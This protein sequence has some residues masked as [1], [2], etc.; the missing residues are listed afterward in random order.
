M[1]TFIYR[2][3]ERAGADGARRGE[4]D[5]PVLEIRGDAYSLWSVAKRL[6]LP[7]RPFWSE[8]TD[9]DGN[10]ADI[11][12]ASADAKA[13]RFAPAAP[14]AADAA[15]DVL[16]AGF[17]NNAEERVWIRVGDAGDYVDIGSVE[18]AVDYMNTLQV[19][20]VDYWVDHS[21]GVGFATP[22]YHGGDFV[23]CFWGDE[24][25]N[26]CRLLSAEERAY[27]ENNLEES[28]L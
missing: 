2:W 24:D 10:P 21:T 28:Y 6:E 8:F 26:F 12:D 17:N 3:Q 14:V 18:D 13:E 5:G 15:C 11:W 7:V 4:V 27:V 23:S 16:P 9:L 19:G 20:K 22:N 25:A 1:Q